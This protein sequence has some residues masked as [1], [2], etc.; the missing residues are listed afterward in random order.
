MVRLWVSFILFLI[1]AFTYDK[2]R[3]IMSSEQ[4]NLPTNMDHVAVPGT[5]IRRQER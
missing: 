5:P 4:R 2:E 1:S 3:T